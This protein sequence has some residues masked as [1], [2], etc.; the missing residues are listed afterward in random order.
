[1][2]NYKECGLKNVWLQNGYKEKDTPYGKAISIQDVEG[3]HRA[4]GMLMVKHKPRLTGT[5]FRFLRKELDLSQAA[6]GAYFGYQAQTV[7]IWEK[8]GRIPKLADR[9]IRAIYREVKEGNTSCKDIVERL[10]DMDRADHEKSRL[11]MRETPRGWEA[12][13]A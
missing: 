10:N 8:T 7:A 2:L 3:L 12:K 13:A 9:A 6:V 4:I 1:M 11:I 5:D